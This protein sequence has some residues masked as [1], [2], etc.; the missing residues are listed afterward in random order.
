MGRQGSQGKCQERAYIEC[1]LTVVLIKTGIG[2]FMMV[3]VNQSA[4][5]QKLSPQVIA[6]PCQQGIIEIE[7]RQIHGIWLD[8]KQIKHQSD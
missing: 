3:A 5:N 4:L 2:G 8:Y 1:P 7:Y 6:I